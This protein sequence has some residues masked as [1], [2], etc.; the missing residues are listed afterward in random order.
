MQI[1]CL[2]AGHQ[3]SSHRAKF[4]YDAQRWTSVCKH[5]EAPMV[6]V[7]RRTWQLKEPR[8]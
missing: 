2:I 8:N 1:V 6:R 7:G 5:C 3:R 4:D